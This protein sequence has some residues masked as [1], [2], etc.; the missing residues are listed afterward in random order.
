M[1]I[2]EIYEHFDKIGTVSFS[3]IDGEYP[4]ARMAHFRAWDE[5]GMYFMT[6]HTKPFYKQL[7]ETGKVAVSG[8]CA[9]T[10]IEHADNGEYAFKPGYAIRI[11]GDVKEVS[12]DDIKAKNNPLF[13]YCIKDQEKYPAMVI[14]CLFRA[15]GDVFD[16][17]FEKSNR[18]HKLERIT[19]SYGGMEKPILG[20]E[21]SKDICIACGKCEKVCSFNAAHKAKEKYEIDRT[22]CDVCGDCYIHCPVQ[23]ISTL[24]K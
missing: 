9:D 24:G 14:F 2:Q 15:K 1:T 13:D 6:M 18:D 22:R 23:A 17:D 16:Y 10:Q 20:L 19:F 21:I 11:S 4:Q 5:D 8:L 3:T 12:M 7:K